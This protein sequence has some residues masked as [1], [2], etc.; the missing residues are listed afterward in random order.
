MSSY[1]DR[2]RVS[3]EPNEGSRS[4]TA[5]PLRASVRIPTIRRPRDEPGRPG[6]EGVLAA[7]GRSQVGFGI[8]R[9]AA[10]IATAAGVATA[11]GARPF[12]RWL[13]HASSPQSLFVFRWML[14]IVNVAG[15]PVFSPFIAA[16]AVLSLVVVAAKTRGLRTGGDVEFGV[17]VMG[18]AAIALMAL[19]L[20]LAVALGLVALAIWLAIVIIVGILIIVVIG[21]LLGSLS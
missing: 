8:I 19:P 11:V 10:A 5:S 6:L 7:R 20:V 14:A 4:P 9:P 12:E 15:M 16:A 3:F 18:I 1:L 2:V 21:V 17:V 13:E